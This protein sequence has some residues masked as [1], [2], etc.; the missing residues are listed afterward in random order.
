MK[1]IVI[2]GIIVVLA[3]A[4]A[5]AY[6]TISKDKTAST[7]QKQQTALVT[8]GNL[9]VTITGSGP[10]ASANRRELSPQVTSM[11]T[12]VNCAEGDKVKSGD[13]LFE[14]DDTDAKMNI[15][16]TQS[17]IAQMQLN[18][19]NDQKSVARA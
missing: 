12:K 14:L 11:L 19:S 5:L 1:R 10:I 7:S 13:V 3:A 8:K 18:I 17:N 4:A 6:I 15:E 16:D 9:D 2:I